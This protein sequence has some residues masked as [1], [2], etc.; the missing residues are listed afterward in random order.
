[1]MIFT[2]PVVG[3]I[4]EMDSAHSEQGSSSA[5]VTLRRPPLHEPLK[6]EPPPEA[7]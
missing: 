5:F 2:Y 7:G 6:L 3:T 1:M 4:S